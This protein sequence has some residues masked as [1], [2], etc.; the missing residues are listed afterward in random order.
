[1]NEIYNG[2]LDDINMKF[3]IFSNKKELEN[4]LKKIRCER[5]DKIEYGI[6]ENFKKNRAL[7]TAEHAYTSRVKTPQYGKKSYVKIGD[8]NTDKLVMMMAHKLR[9]SFLIS[10]L[11]RVD[12]DPNRPTNTLGEDERILLEIFKSKDEDK[13]Y[14]RVHRNKDYA[15]FLEKYHSTIEELNPSGLVSV[16][17][18]S[19]KAHPPDILLGFGRNYRIIDG[20]ENALKFKKLFIKKLNEALSRFK[21]ENKLK[22][23]ISK[24]LFTGEKNYVLSKHVIQYNKTNKNKR[25]GMHVEFNVRGRIVRENFIRKDYQ[26][27][28][29]VLADTVLEWLKQH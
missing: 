13:K 29:Q 22:I 19:E 11:S 18:M 16:H 24:S 4:F 7:F 5:L 8:K 26:I 9:S 15:P 20:T 12:A 25:F 27:A 28:T 21:I 2:I 23:N 17:G 14:F 10:R 1:M 3:V 6:L